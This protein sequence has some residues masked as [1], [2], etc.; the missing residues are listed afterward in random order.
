DSLTL[1]PRLEC[2]GTILAHCNLHFPGSNN[3][4]VPA[5][6][7]AGTTDAHHQA[8]LI[9][10]FL[11]ETGFR[12]VGQAGLELL[13]SGDPPASASQSA[14]ITGVS[15]RPWPKFLAEMRSH[16]IARA[17]LELLGLG[18]PKCWDYRHEPPC[19]AD[20]QLS[21][22]MFLKQIHSILGG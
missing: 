18:L 8:Q 21:K 20:T 15:H 5:S 3:S 12:H 13:T 9:F 16:Y 6:Q 7:V 4:P 10:V 2:N 14:G 17:V 19:P 22:R 1:S 11:V